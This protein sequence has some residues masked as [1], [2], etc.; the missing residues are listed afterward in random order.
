MSQVIENKR[1]ASS[2]ADSLLQVNRLLYDL[3]PEI[4]LTN[5][6]SHTMDLFQQSTYPQNAPMILESQTGS[7][8]VDPQG[9]WFEF[10]VSA[11]NSGTVSTNV[12][13]G[14]AAN[15][16]QESLVTHRTGTELSRCQ[17]IPLYVRN[18]QGWENDS[19]WKTHQG[20]LQGYTPISGTATD[21]QG[22]SEMARFAIPLACVSPFF[23]GRKLIPPQIM[24]GLRLRITLASVAHALVSASDAP[25]GF[26]IHTP[27]IMWN[28]VTLA[29]AFRRK[30]SEISA[31]KGLVMLHKEV[32][33]QRTSANATSYNFEIRKAVAKALACHVVSRLDTTVANAAGNVDPLTS[34]V[35]A[36]TRGQARIGQNYFPN[37]ALEGVAARPAAFYAYTLHSYGKLTNAGDRA[38]LIA[39][40]QTTGTAG[41]YVGTTADARGAIA[42]NLNKSS[43]SDMDGISVNNSRSLVIDLQAASAA[44][45]IDAF[46]VHLRMVRAF[47]SNAEVRD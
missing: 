46:L 23:S 43:V 30:I 47:P 15:F 3:P 8:F 25:T 21:L 37:Q 1:P 44:R 22:A 10:G 39:Y 19:N 33:H 27:R 13:S 40:D 42:F 9:S 4:S 41:G 11:T 29:D 38:S 6:K 32:F 2:V 12:G 28:T 24:E 16:L 45:T 34:E 18:K 20:P 7:A 17:E 31:Q 5:G 35:F 36:W 26:T 14:S